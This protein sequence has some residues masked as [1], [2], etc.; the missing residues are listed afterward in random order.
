MASILFRIER[1]CHSQFKC[2]YLRN[3]TIFLNFLFHFCNLHQLWNIWRKNVMVIAI[4]FP[5]LESLKNF[6]R[7]FYQKR[8]FGTRSYSQDVKVSQVLAKSP[9]ESF[10]HAFWSFW[11]KLIWK[12]SPVVLGKILGPFVTT[13]DCRWQVSCSILREFSTLNSN[14]I[15]WKM[16][17]SFSIFY[18]ISGIYIDFYTCFFKK[19]NAHS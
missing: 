9:W 8:R 14:A 3:K 1:I 11:G 6:V 2:H 19:D 5:K 7:P 12:K 13:I 18:S 4:I 15:I 17:N 10:Y 16:K